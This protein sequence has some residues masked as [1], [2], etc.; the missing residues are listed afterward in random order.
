MLHSAKLL[1]G[2]AL[3]ALLAVSAQAAEI[4][5]ADSQG[6]A[7]AY[8]NQLELT[9][10]TAAG[11]TPTF[12]ENPDIAALNARIQGNPESLPPVAERLPSEPLVVMPYEAIGSYGGVL[13]VLSNATEAGT[14]DVLSLRHVNLVRFADDTQTIVPNV[15][16]YWTWNDDFTELTFVLRTGHKWSDGEPFTAADVVF[17]Y[18]D[19]ILNAQ[20]YEKTP[21]AWLWDGTPATVEALDEVTVKFTLPISAPGLLG[22]FAISH[23]QPFQPQHFLGQFMEK[24]NADAAALREAMGFGTE[25]EA[26]NWFYG[27]SDWK[28]V[29]QP[30]LKDPARAASMPKAVLPTLEAYI[31]VDDTAE[32]RRLVANPFFHQIDTAGSQLPYINEIN[33]LYVPEKADRSAKI[34]NGEVDYKTQSLFLADFSFYKENDGQGAYTVHLV[35]TVGETIYYAFNVDDPDFGRL[36]EQ[37]EFR[38][39]MSLAIDRDEILD[40]VYLGQGE[41]VQATPAEPGT[42]AFLTEEHLT[43]FTHYDP[44]A[45][46]TILDRLGAKDS[47]GDGVREFDGKD[48][49]I[50][51]FFAKQGG[52]VKAHELVRGYW[53]RIGVKVDQSEIS[54]EDYRLKGSAADLSI[55][56]WR[57]ASR[58][59]VIIAQDP[60]MFVPPF[61]NRWQP[62]TGYQWAAWLR[63]EGAEGREP[64]AAVKQLVELSNSFKAL[65]LGSEESNEIGRQIADIHAENLWKI[66]LVGS[67]IQ[68]AITSNNLKNFRPFTSATY[69]YYWA[70]PYA[71]TQWYLTQ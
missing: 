27:G 8:P 30:I 52:P 33:E 66:G 63:T 14:T 57:D 1:S 51:M 21:A 43:A 3:A 22:R 61:G 16:K 7:G 59:G 41:P 70:Y 11:Q 47:N 53:E 67:T 9:E 44:D 37:V 31:V 35:P 39:A 2:V 4:T 48:L 20:V 65:P 19:L 6:V 32:G 13:D 5:V 25:G 40:L 29:P 36:F 18:D 12:A 50:R 62:G 42:V 15:A 28:D 26:I 49:S 56:S 69:D 64:P 46:N 17:W 23:A 34:V 55:A 71:P 58:A 68:P 60:F 45:A 54:T 10:L 24:H 38:K